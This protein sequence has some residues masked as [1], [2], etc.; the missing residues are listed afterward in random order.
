M[1]KLWIKKIRGNPNPNKFGL[2]LET[3]KKK[4]KSEEEEGGDGER[5][6]LREGLPYALID[7]FWGT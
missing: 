1:I 4:K 2:N 7:Q 6:G 3:Y 5:D